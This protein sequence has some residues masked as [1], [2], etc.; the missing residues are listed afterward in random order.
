MKPQHEIAQEY[1]DFIAWKMESDNAFSGL[2]PKEQEV[3]DMATAHIRKALLP[4][5][6]NQPWYKRIF[7]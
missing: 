5:V 1:L 3:Y 7:G 2:T 6:P 4:K